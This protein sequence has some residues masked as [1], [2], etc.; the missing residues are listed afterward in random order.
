MTDYSILQTG[1]DGF[2]NWIAKIFSDWNSEVVSFCNQNIP[3]IPANRWT[4][5]ASAWTDIYSY[6]DNLI[7]GLIT[8][9]NVEK[10]IYDRLPFS[11]DLKQNDNIKLSDLARDE[12]SLIAEIN[13][14]HAGA[15][16]LP[17]AVITT[18]GFAMRS[19]FDPNT[20]SSGVLMPY[21]Q[22]TSFI[23]KRSTLNRITE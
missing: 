22:Y 6:T 1:H 3:A 5:R 8:M 18:K 15:E 9:Y 11:Y 17:Y 12:A 2:D 13:S 10:N 14:D 23:R 16:D 19:D 20:G 21:D 7:S 4:M